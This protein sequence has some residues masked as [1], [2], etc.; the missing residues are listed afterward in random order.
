[1]I[2]QVA[3]FLENEGIGVVGKTIFKAS[4]PN[5]VNCIVLSDSGGLQSNQNV[6]IDNP[7]IQIMIRADISNGGYKKAMDTA[8]SIYALLDKKQNITIG[9]VHALYSRAIQRPY[10][11]G[12]S[13]DDEIKK[14]VWKVVNNYLFHIRG[15]I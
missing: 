8:K 14:V 7:T 13:T 5:R 10:S 12:L 1:M 11:L 9:T 15:T 2:E 6:P 4:A 3:Q